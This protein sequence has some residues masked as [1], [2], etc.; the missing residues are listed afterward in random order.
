MKRINTL[1]RS[2]TAPVIGSLLL[3]ALVLAACGGGGSDAGT[4]VASNY[5]AGTITGFGSVIVNGVRYDDSSASVNGEDD[6]ST[7]TSSLKIG[8]QVEVESEGV[9][10][11][12]DTSGAQTCTAKAGRISHGGNSLVGPVDAGSLI[13]GTSF[14]LLGQKVLISSTTTFNYDSTT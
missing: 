14:T 8:M 5:A 6:S 2:N 7:S 9:V 13:S 3:S 10:C 11:S 12:T 1:R 4:P